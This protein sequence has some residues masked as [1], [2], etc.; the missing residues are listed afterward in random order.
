MTVWDCFMYNGEYEVLLARLRELVGLVDH[1]VLVES[2]TTFSGR[3]KP[4]YFRD[5]DKARLSAAHPIVHIVVDNSLP[6]MPG[7][8]W[9]R[10]S[11]QRN[12]AL[13]ALLGVNNGGPPAAEPGDLVIVSDV[14]EIPRRSLIQ[15][16]RGI[17][18]EKPV[19]FDMQLSYYALNWQAR[20]PWHHAFAC[21]YAQLT[22]PHEQRKNAQNDLYPRI[23]Q[24]GWHVAY[25]MDARRIQEKLLSFS[26]IEYAQP[27]YTDLDYIDDCISCGLHLF[28]RGPLDFKEMPDAPLLALEE[29]ERFESW[30]RNWSPAAEI[31]IRYQRACDRPS[32]IN[33]HLPVLRRLAENVESVVE[34]G[35]RDVVSSW[36]LLVAMPKRLRCYDIHR[37][38]QVDVLARLGQAVYQHCD[39]AF[40]QADTLKAD[41]EPCDLLFI[42][43]VHTYAQLSAELTRHA[44][45]VRKRIVLHDTETYGEYGEDGGPGIWEAIGELLATGEWYVEERYRN[46]NGLTVLVRT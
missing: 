29:P 7:N 22:D 27:P 2:T 17:P 26:H 6:V 4:A 24:A 38:L 36:A 9:I 31:A 15:R 28:S 42:D 45:K 14:D 5:V 16:L 35:V 12:A 19:A 18:P 3:K 13:R 43:T 44:S 33:E 10:E 46:N 30:R 1:H 23:S 20:A 25:Q 11:Y 8:V 40:M 34:F 39:F 21:R 37:S 32:D 41:I